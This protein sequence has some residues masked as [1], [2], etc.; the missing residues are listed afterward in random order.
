MPR[1]GMLVAYTK[2]TFG[3]WIAGFVACVYCVEYLLTVGLLNKYCSFYMRI[4]FTVLERKNDVQG[5]YEDFLFDPIAFGVV[6][7]AVIIHLMGVRVTIS[8]LA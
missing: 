1:N 2:V 8:M 6:F 3:Q 7:G 5:G 4:L